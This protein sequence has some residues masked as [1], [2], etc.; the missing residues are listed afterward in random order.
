MKMRNMLSL[1][2]WVVLMVSVLNHFM[3][4]L[5]FDHYLALLDGK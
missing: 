1:D 5:Y 4:A 2:T 3:Y